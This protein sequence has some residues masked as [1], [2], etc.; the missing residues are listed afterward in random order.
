LPIRP[1]NNFDLSVVKSIS[2]KERYKFQF[3]AGAWNVLNHAQ[4]LPGSVNNIN[5]LGYT[6]GATLSYLTP[7][8]TTFNHP[9]ATFSNNARSMQL[10]ARF[11]F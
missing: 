9:E 4:Y 2:F 8:S 10:F 11:M 6:D 3:G 5:S 7:G 1:I